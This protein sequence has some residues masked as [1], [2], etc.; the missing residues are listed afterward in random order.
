MINSFYKGKYWIGVYE[1]SPRETLLAL[2]YNPHD[3]GKI[4]NKTD[5]QMH[6]IIT[7]SNTRNNQIVFNH[8]TCNLVLIDIFEEDIGKTLP[9][10]MRYWQDFDCFDYK[11]P[12]NLHTKDYTYKINFFSLR[13]YSRYRIKDITYHYG[14][15]DI[16]TK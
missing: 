15:L 11:T 10:F 6:S 13:F 4:L 2:G 14:K 3:L 1:K 5:C 16:W 9:A 7:H 8:K 12:V